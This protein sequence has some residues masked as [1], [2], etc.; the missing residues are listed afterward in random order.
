MKSF[1]KRKFIWD[2]TM[3]VCI[4]VL[5]IIMY[6]HTLF[7]TN[8]NSINVF[9]WEYVHG[10]A[11]NDTFVWGACLVIIPFI[12]FSLWYINNTYWWK[13]YILLP[14][15]VSLNLIT[16]GFFKFPDFI[17]KYILFVL[18]FFIVLVWRVLEKVRRMIV[19]FEVIDNLEVTIVD[20][21]NAIK[22]KYR[23]LNKSIVS[24]REN[25]ELISSD[26]Y[27]KK[28]TSTQ[29]QIKQGLQGVRKSKKNYERR[30]NFD[31]LII[32]CF[33]FCFFLI[34]LNKLLPERF[35]KSILVV[36]NLNN[37]G[38]PDIQTY[39]YLIEVKLCLLIPL[40][41]WYVTQKNWWRYA[42]FS[43]ITLTMYQ[44][45]EITLPTYYMD[46]V[47]IWHAMPVVI[48][49][50][51]FTA[52]LSKLINY[53]FRILDIYKELSNE[54]EFLLKQ[55]GNKQNKIKNEKKQFEKIVVKTKSAEK[56]NELL[57]LKEELQ[58][59]L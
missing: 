26:E 55:I 59:K 23:Y 24:L 40:F 3:A 27:L 29:I 7:D 52:M 44:L 38:F 2:V 36:F 42:I 43:P 9:G 13:D 39:I 16:T 20:Y 15:V 11:G 14:M 10:L 58:N 45:W 57:K 17:E 1:W 50:I 33:I 53:K 4:T 37:Y 19:K 21:L 56:L 41:L 25:R 46:E 51:L 30:N 5:P 18:F 8:K 6:T 28:I 54:I 32:A 31:F 12:L 48:L 49:I 35:L 34:Q 22:G 47:S